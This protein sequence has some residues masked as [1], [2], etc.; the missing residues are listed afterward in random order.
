MQGGRVHAQIRPYL[1]P[2]SAG[3]RRLGLEARRIREQAYDRVADDYDD[4][5]SRHVV[6]PNARLTESLR[7][8]AGERVADLACGT[9]VDTVEMARAGRARRGDGVD[10]SEGMLAAARDRAEDAG[11][12]LTLRPRA[13]RGVH[14]AAPRPPASTWSRCASCSPTSTGRRCC[15]AWGAL[16]RRG[17]RVGVLTSLAGSIPQFFE[18]YHKFR[19]SPE[20]AWKLFQHTRR[21]LGETWRMFRQL[22]DLRRRPLHHRARHRG[23]RWPRLWSAAA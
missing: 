21:D 11:V 5:L 4:L 3:K 17:G 12:S 19:K 7:I 23:D 10:Y 18:L 1:A 14:R 16:L 6:D 9:G 13:G 2:R 22:G 20:P 15:P 8:A